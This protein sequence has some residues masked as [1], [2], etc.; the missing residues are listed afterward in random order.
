MPPTPL[1]SSARDFHHRLRPRHTE[2]WWAALLVEAAWTTM[3]RLGPREWLNRGLTTAAIALVL[4]LGTVTVHGVTG[5][6]PPVVNR[7]V[8][9]LVG[10]GDPAVS[11][12]PLPT[13]TTNEEAV[14]DPTEPGDLVRVPDLTGRPLSVALTVL[15]NQLHLQ[16]RLVW[17]PQPGVAPT[18]TVVAQSPGASTVSRDTVVVLT[19][20]ATPAGIRR[21]TTPTAPEVPV[22]SSPGPAATGFPAIAPPATPRP[23]PTPAPKKSTPT[24]RTTPTKVPTPTATIPL[25]A[26]PTDPAT[27]TTTQA[28][29]VDGEQPAAAPAP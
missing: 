8:L 28:P 23:T 4:A 16:V 14:A 20:R 6:R 12:A 10:G 17:R 29:P 21:F 19:V 27:P 9:H 18:A 5:Q 13:S 11:P 7:M 25:I 1:P 15:Q 24:P 22:T 2:T 3:R 26:P